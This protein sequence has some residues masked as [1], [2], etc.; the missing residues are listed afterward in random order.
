MYIGAVEE[1]GGDLS[2]E[3]QLSEVEA[4]TRPGHASVLLLSPAAWE[5]HSAR[6]GTLYALLQTVSGRQ[7]PVHDL[8]TKMLEETKKFLANG[9][10]DV[11]VTIEFEIGKSRRN[12]A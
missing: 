12:P 3:E 1:A 2:M 10:S 4:P 11:T 6:P 8:A 9:R 5:G 7:Q